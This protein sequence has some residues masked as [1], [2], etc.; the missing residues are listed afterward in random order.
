MVEMIFQPPTA[1]PMAIA[2][3]QQ[4]LTHNG[5]SNVSIKPPLSKVKVIIPIA[6]CASLEP[7]EKAIMMADTTCMDLNLS[8]NVIGE[9]LPKI[10]N[11]TFITI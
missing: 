11:N 10:S 3:A 4:S 7:C 1:V 8:F 5:T 2:V 6:F 9:N